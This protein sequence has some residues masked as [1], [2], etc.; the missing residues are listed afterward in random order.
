M[1]TDEPRAGLGASSRSAEPPAAEPEPSALGARLRAAAEER[2][3]AAEARSREALGSAA[4]AAERASFG[5][6]LGARQAQAAPP[7]A[8]F[9]AHTKGIGGKLLAKMGYR[10][11]EGLGRRGTGMAEALQTKLRP[12][13]MGMGFN[14]Y[15]E[16]P[17]AEQSARPPEAAQARN[18]VAPPKDGWKRRQ[19]DARP[20]AVYKTA[21]ELLREQEAA[22]GASTPREGVTVIDMRSG[23]ARV[24]TKL[25]RLSQAPSA[26][27]DST[28]MPELQHNLRLLVDLAES[29]IGSLDRRLRAER[30][31]CEA[32]KREAARA[33]EELRRRRLAAE[34]AQQMQAQLGTALAAGGATEVAAAL[35]LLAGQHSEAWATHNLAAVALSQALPHL[36][37]ALEG[38]APLAQPAWGVQQALLWRPLLERR[39]RDES[40]FEDAAPSDCYA[41]LLDASALPPMR[42]CVANEWAAESPEPLLSALEA[43]QPALPAASLRQLLSA[44]VLPKLAA[45]VDAWQPQRSLVPLHCWLH[46]WLPWFSAAGEDGLRAL[47]PPIRH[48]LATALQAWHPADSS[49]LALLSPWRPVWAERDWDSLLTRSILPKLGWALQQLVI[50]PAAQQLGPLQWLLAWAPFAPARLLAPL[51]DAHFFPAWHAALHAW[52]R[53]TAPPPDYGEVTRWYLGW[54]G[55]FPQELTSHERVR[56]GFNAA[57]DLMNAA[58]AG[59]LPQAPPAAPSGVAGEAVQAAQEVK[60]QVPIGR[61]GA[62]ASLRELLERFAESRSVP[63]LPKPGRSHGGMQVYAFG[64][65]SCVVDSAREALLAQTEGGWKSVSMEQMMQMHEARARDVGRS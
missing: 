40:L 51:L 56:R 37:A 25:E 41:V 43:W 14:E 31:T 22:A 24:V 11:G 48:K 15:S 64:R 21:E 53:S 38:W 44:A 10:P 5:P 17:K 65:V 60:E 2:R 7:G 55:L 35:R 16:Q 47:Y 46:P 32:L 61:T 12:K 13:G 8:S 50:N 23:H 62:D 28:P 59:Q 36:C 52:L 18:S 3:R 54:K 1:E 45:A 42:S 4:G 26:A 39:A 6:A 33:S 29:Q 63:F 49:A 27:E 34:Q 57:L 19:R 58:V 20:K 9:E 30:D